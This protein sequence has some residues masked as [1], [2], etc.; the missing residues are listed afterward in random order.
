MYAALWLRARGRGCREDWPQSPDAETGC[1]WSLE[2]VSGGDSSSLLGQGLISFGA[3]VAEKLPGLPHFRNHVEIKIG[4]QYLVFIT[5]GLSENLAARIAEVTLAVKLADVPR[6]FRTHTIDCTHE[7]AIG[8]R[9]RGLLQFPQIFGKPRDRG[10]RI[11]YNLRAVQSEDAC[12]FR[13]MPVI[14][15]INSDGSVLGLENGIAEITG[16][17]VELLPESG[18][19]V[20]DVMFAV[21]TQIASV[22]IYD[23]CGIEVHP[24][25][26]LF[27]NRDHDHH[28]VLGSDLLHQFNCGSVRNSFREFVP[29]D[30]LLGTEIWAVKQLL[31]AKY[32]HLL[33]RRLLDE[34]Q[35]LIDHGLLDLRQRAVAAHYIPC[36]DETT[37]HNAGHRMHLCERVNI[38]DRHILFP[39]RCCAIIGDLLEL[40][41]A[42]CNFLGE[43][44]CAALST[45][46]FGEA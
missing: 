24:R 46:A 39:R 19:H 27:V 1:L 13:K 18:M 8:Y 17:E 11:K 22:R 40:A 26:L 4:S 9:V 28:V 21:L 2:S 12:A 14:A 35:V 29:A 44:S 6:L 42:L 31:Q 43:W 5:A 7:I 45:A 37:A 33:F 3:A 10:G 34:L 32:L 16:R 41:E 20:R 15:D 25:H 23:G 36:L 30:V 38:A